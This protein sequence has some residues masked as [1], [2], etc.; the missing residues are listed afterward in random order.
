MSLAPGDTVKHKTKILL[1]G[2]LAFNI[3]ESDG[4]YAKCEYFD[5]TSEQQHV[6]E[7]FLISDLILVNKVKGGF[8]EN[9]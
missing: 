1:N 6:Q 2:G 7:I 4:D 3:L 9:I 5:N 8:T